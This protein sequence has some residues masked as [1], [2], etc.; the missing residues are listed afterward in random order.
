MSRSASSGSTDHPG[1]D[2]SNHSGPVQGSPARP[3]R[4]PPERPPPPGG[5]KQAPAKP[6]P[7][8]I[9]QAKVGNS[10]FFDTL[11]WHDQQESLIESGSDNE[12]SRTRNDSV[13]DEFA[14]LSSQRISSD[15][16]GQSAFPQDSANP[17]QTSPFFEADFGD[18]PAPS[19]E[20]VVD[21]LNMAGSSVEPVAAGVDL[22]NLEPEPSTLELLTGIAE[23]SSA[24]LLG[25]DLNFLGA[26]SGPTNSQEHSTPDPFPSQ[27][28]PQAQPAQASAMG[29]FDFL[30]NAGSMSGSFHADTSATKAPMDDFMAFMDSSTPAAQSATM[31][32]GP[33]LMGSWGSQPTGL[34]GGMGA[35]PGQP[36]TTPTQPATSPGFGMAAPQPTPAQP[37]Q[38][39]QPKAKA[40][41]F[42]DLGKYIAVLI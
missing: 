23:P 42:A 20:P 5:P 13:E 3:H 22:L 30:Q 32:S 31:D 29:D 25:D 41:P 15:T 39:T 1:E 2:L 8:N 38:P 26:P 40:D 12:T 4:K 9:G 24:N 27:P 35:Q 7:P 17:E 34:M 6:P 18:T 14:A 16:T 11:E 36:S 28:Q 21:L 33:D 10:N 37:S 19:A